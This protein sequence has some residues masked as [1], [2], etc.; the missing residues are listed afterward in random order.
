MKPLLA[1]ALALALSTVGCAR[2]GGPLYTHGAEFIPAF[3]TAT[4]K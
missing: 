3:D 4:D 1:L 2:G